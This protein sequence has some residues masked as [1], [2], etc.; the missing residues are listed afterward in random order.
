M[1]PLSKN[2]FIALLSRGPVASTGVRDLAG[3]CQSSGD[4]QDSWACVWRRKK[5]F[6]QLGP[7]GEH[8]QS[9]RTLVVQ[10]QGNLR[11]AHK[12]V[13]AW[14]SVEKWQRT[15]VPQLQCYVLRCAS[16]RTPPPTH[17]STLRR[18]SLNTHTHTGANT[19]CC[20]RNALF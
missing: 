8:R 4:L 15:H 7:A 16:V 10:K 18:I 20:H 14:Q 9:F 19:T 5:N 11:W 3:F 6:P 1:K 13:Q 12:R 2:K 17:L